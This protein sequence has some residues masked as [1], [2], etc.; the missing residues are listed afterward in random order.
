MGKREQ[1]RRMKVPSQFQNGFTVL[2][3]LV[4][5]LLLA[6]LVT[7][8]T[9]IFN[10]SSIAWRTGVASV[11][12]LYDVRKNLGAYHDIEDD[13]LPGLGGPGN[14]KYRTVSIFS[15]WN[16]SGVPSTKTD[17]LYEEFSETMTINENSDVLGFDRKDLTDKV[18]VE[19]GHAWVVG[20]RSLGPDKL[21]ETDDDISTIPEEVE[22]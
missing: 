12:D 22:R 14:Y 6:M 20:V 19:S 8:L 17:R 9:M 16:G 3:L 1:G 10:Q 13:L 4:A 7:M 18:K 5:S 11:R 2:E 21:P 15:G